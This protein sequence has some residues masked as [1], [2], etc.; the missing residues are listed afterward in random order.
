MSDAKTIAFQS[1]EGFPIAA[2][3]YG[4]LPRSRV[5]QYGGGQTRHAWGGAAATS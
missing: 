5:V 2:D 3:A 4:T 1:S